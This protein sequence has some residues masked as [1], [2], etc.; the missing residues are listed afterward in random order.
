MARI[1]IVYT[2]NAGNLRTHFTS[3]AE[4]AGSGSG[5]VIASEPDFNPEVVYRAVVSR[6]ELPGWRFTLPNRANP[7]RSALRGN[8]HTIAGDAGP[9]DAPRRECVGPGV[10]VPRV[11]GF[12]RAVERPAP[13]LS[14][15]V[16]SRDRRDHSPAGRRCLYPCSG[17]GADDR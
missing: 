11:G 2:S 4:V 7:K 5:G 13:R 6:L 1:P 3:V 12:D 15:F 16:G 9:L 17:K 8:E 14:S 10:R